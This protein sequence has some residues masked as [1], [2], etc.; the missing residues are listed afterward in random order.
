MPWHTFGWTCVRSRGEYDW[1]EEPSALA[2]V[3]T[4]DM[5]SMVSFRAAT[6]PGTAKD[7]DADRMAITSPCFG[8]TAG[9][10]C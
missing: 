4:N 2:A 8:A 5:E 7:A 1:H 10:S 6:L 9:E 3:V